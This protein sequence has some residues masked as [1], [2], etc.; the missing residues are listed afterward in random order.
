MSS[1][2][3]LLNFL[4][5]LFFVN[6]SFF[7]STYIVSG[8]GNLHVYIAQFQSLVMLDFAIP[9]T[10]H[11]RAF[12]YHQLWASPNSVHWPIH[13]TIFILCHSFAFGLSQLSQGLSNG[14]AFASG[15]Q[16]WVSLQHRPSMNTR[17]IPFRMDQVDFA[18]PRLSRAFTAQKTLAL[19]F[20]IQLSNAITTT[21]TIPD[22]WLVIKPR[23]FLLCRLLVKQSS[24]KECYLYL[25]LHTSQ[26]FLSSK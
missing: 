11:A 21:E 25:R 22:Y 15:G 10:T 26:W 1:F 6:I 4:L 13:P 19:S 23:R 24:F 18:A 14:S 17:L 8:S 12:V 2:T 20:Y 9:W 5:G 3:S 7:V 16:H